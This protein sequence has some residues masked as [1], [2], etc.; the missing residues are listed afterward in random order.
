MTDKNWTEVINSNQREKSNS[1]NQSN[2]EF[3][4]RKTIL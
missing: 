4:K 2:L 3:K 1:L